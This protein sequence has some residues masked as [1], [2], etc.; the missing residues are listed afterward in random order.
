[1]TPAGIRLAELAE[2]LGLPLEG[3]GSVVLGSGRAVIYADIWAAIIADVPRAVL[4][5]L[6]CTLVVVAIAFRRRFALA[7]TMAA[8][9]AGVA[10]MTGGL[11]ASGVRLNFLNFIALPITFGIGVD[12]AVNVMQR[13]L[14]DGVGSAL[15]AVRATGSAV[16][17][18][19]LTTALGYLALVKS[20]NY[21]VR[22][23]GIA[24]VAGEI[25][26]L[27]VAVLLLP[28]ALVWRDGPRPR[29]EA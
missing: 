2:A 28:A 9:L 22:S 19:S 17:L 12:Y 1:M 15:R 29:R 21:A 14:R 16:I 26:C 4:V 8:L 3:D 24:A 13:Y 10:W 5:S 18:C 6:A 11:G 23:L 27:V 20:D 25:A 7:V